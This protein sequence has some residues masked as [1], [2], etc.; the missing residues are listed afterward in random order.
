MRSSAMPIIICASWR[1][2]ARPRPRPKFD[3]PR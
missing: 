2:A 1:D 3:P